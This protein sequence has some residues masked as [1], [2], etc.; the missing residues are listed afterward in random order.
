MKDV[1]RNIRET[2]NVLTKIEDTV[3]TRD[4]EFFSSFKS[5]IT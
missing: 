5:V 2:N 3:Q 4:K 1:D